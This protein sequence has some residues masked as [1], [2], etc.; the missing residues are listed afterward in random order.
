MRFISHQKS[1]KDICREIANYLMA[2]NIDVCFDED[3]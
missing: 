3:V 1:D 2:A